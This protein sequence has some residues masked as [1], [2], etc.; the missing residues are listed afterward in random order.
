MSMRLLNEEN[1]EAAWWSVPVSQVGH[2]AERNALEQSLVL[3]FVPERGA[4]T[5]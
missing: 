4:G 2:A 3:R 1:D 5:L